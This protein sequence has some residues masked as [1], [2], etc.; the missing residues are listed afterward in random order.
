MGQLVAAARQ[1][2]VHQWWQFER[3]NYDIFVSELVIL[4]ARKGDPTAVQRRLEVLRDVPVLEIEPD[5]RELAERLI[6]RTG[7]PDKAAADA[8]HIAVAAT[9]GMD[10]LLTLNMRHIANIHFREAIMQECRDAG[11]EP[12]LTCTPDEML[13]E[14][15]E[16]ENDG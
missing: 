8:L 6:A 15:P 12:P 9:S 2:V 13:G 4:E 11:F 14:L 7:L 16:E 10:F 3:H 1:R 5:A